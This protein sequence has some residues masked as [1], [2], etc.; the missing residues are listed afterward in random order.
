M[1]RG[2]AMRGARRM[3]GRV[4]VAGGVVGADGG[5]VVCE[6]SQVVGVRE[7]A[8]GIERGEEMDEEREKGTDG[9]EKAGREM[10]PEGGKPLAGAA[11]YGP[12]RGDG[13]GSRDE[14]T[15]R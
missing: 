15:C 6:V 4:V 13:D 9:G 14:M 11:R 5:A 2:R 1:N 10:T 12:V 8:R 7:V 3:V